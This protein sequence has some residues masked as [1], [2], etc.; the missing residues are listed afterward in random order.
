LAN[1]GNA[2]EDILFLGEA[3]LQCGSILLWYFKP[4]VQLLLS[5]K[6]SA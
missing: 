5:I 3:A 4:M 1:L 2:F 6:L